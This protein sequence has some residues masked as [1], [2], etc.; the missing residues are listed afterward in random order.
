M[1]SECQNCHPLIPES[2]SG[3]MIRP[4]G[5]RY[6]DHYTYKR[7]V[8]SKIFYLATVNNL[9]INNLSISVRKYFRKYVRAEVELL[10]RCTVRST[11]V[12]SYES[13]FVK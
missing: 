12:L 8:P 1:G 5:N 7:V 10:Q 3:S 4:Y 6:F 13:T 11:F 2:T 9:E